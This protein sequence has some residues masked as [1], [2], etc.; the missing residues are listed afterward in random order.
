[1]D[2]ACYVQV[3]HNLIR[4]NKDVFAHKATYKE[5]LFAV[6]KLSEEEVDH[7]PEY[8]IINYAL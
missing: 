5:V 1:M 4:N 3:T 8:R 6:D 2:H 7:Y